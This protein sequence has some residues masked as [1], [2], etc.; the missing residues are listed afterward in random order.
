MSPILAEV[1]EL[2]KSMPNWVH[3]KLAP[4]EDGEMGKVPFIVGTQ[5][6]ASSTRSST[7]TTFE[8]ATRNASLSSTEGVGFVI[9]GEA[10]KANLVGVDL[11]GCRNPQTGE[12]TPWAEKIISVLDSYTEITPSKTGVRVWVKGK[13]PGQDRVFHLDPATGVGEKVQIEIFDRARYFTMTGQSLFEGEGASDI[14]TRDL[15]EV[16][17]LCQDFR[18]KYPA[19]AKSE[20]PVLNDGASSAE[21]AQIN[22][23]GTVITD[24]LDLLMTGEIVSRKPFVVTDGMGNSIEYASHSEAD[25]ALCTALAL[26]YGNQP[27]LIFGEYEQSSLYR[28]KWGNRSGYFKDHTIA[29]AIKTADRIKSQSQQTQT[30]VSTPVSNEIPLPADAIGRT[31]NGVPIF[32]YPKEENESFED[33]STIAELEARGD[34]AVEYPDPGKADLVSLFAYQLASG[35]SL[36]LAF[37]RET[38]KNLTNQLIDGFYLHPVYPHLSLRGFHFNYGPSWIGKTTAFDLVMGWMK[39]DFEERNIWM[40]DLLSHGSRQYFIRMHTKEVPLGKDGKPK[41]QAGNPHQFHHVKEG[42]RIASDGMD[43]YFKSIFSLVT[44]LYDQTEAST[45]SFS[46]DDWVAKDVRIS[47]IICITPTDFRLTFQGKGSIGSGGLGRWTIVAPPKVENKK[48]WDRMPSDKLW[49]TFTQLRTRFPFVAKTSLAAQP[50]SRPVVLTEEEGAKEIR[51]ATHNRME[52]AGKMGVRLTEYFIREQV[53][54]AA[55]SIEHPNVMT[56]EDAER[57]SEWT[58]AQLKARAVWPPDAGNPVEVHEVTIRRTV[59]RHLVSETK[60]KDACHYYRPGSGGSWSF[61]TALA[62]MLKD[63][64]KCVGLAGQ[65]R[66]PVFCPKWC[67]EHP[68]V[69]I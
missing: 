52:Q 22:K 21:G 27:D 11:D 37:V 19:K 66:T 61:A 20:A 30:K 31:E 7:W 3:W 8:E 16:Y 51:L 26:K 10:V 56:R 60:L 45:G 43:K 67:K 23:T 40:R 53:N 38:L 48:D 69:R 41:W 39:K 12:L 68:R 32:E 18:A 49:E 47:S 65:R 50:T 35:T 2:L 15:T 54:R 17:Q 44:D 6:Y 9:H 57:I 64:I 4:N 1:P 29:K 58:D 25:L 33:I 14:Q 5:K 34:V 24:K 62:N 42:N 46:N 63:D 13:L 36:P 28:E 55:F 59:I